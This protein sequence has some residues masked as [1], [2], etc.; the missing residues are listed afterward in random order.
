[1]AKNRDTYKYHVKIGGKIIYRG[2]TRDLDKRSS[3]HKAHW[4]ESHVV[5]VGRKTTRE[6]AIEW[7]KQG[8]RSP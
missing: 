5:K 3:Q 1:M 8:G 6:K 2:I 7:E 4:P